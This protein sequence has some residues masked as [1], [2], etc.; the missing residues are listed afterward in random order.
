MHRTLAMTSNAATPQPSI[1]G[2]LSAG[3]PGDLRHHVREQQDA[4]DC[5][6]DPNH[7]PRPFIWRPKQAA[8]W[9][10]LARATGGP[11]SLIRT[12]GTVGRPVAGM[13]SAAHMAGAAG[14]VV[15]SLTVSVPVRW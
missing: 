11:W 10:R 8:P 5:I 15:G 1:S 9:L 4:E 2:E 7:R 12:E 14:C 3:A 13:A 6:H